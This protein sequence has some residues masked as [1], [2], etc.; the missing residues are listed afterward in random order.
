MS[1]TTT[2]KRLYYIMRWRWEFIFQNFVN[3]ISEE[4]HIFTKF[5]EVGLMMIK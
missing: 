4:S 5:T 1:G 3:T 2:T